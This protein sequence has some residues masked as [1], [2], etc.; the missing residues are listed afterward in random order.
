MC[1]SSSV[2]WVRLGLGGWMGW[3][4]RGSAVEICMAVDPALHASHSFLFSPP[5]LSSLS[6]LVSSLRSRP[7]LSAPLR[8]HSHQIEKCS[9]YSRFRLIRVRSVPVRVIGYRLSSMLFLCGLYGMRPIPFPYR[10]SPE[11][12]A[13][14][15]RRTTLAPRKRTSFRGTFNDM[16]S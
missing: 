8:A 14:R 16:Y 9:I 11:H 12:F 1:E 2:R 3:I 5:L 6:R 15:A 7:R 13:A 4:A 10:R